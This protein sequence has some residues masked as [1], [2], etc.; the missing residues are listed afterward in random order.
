MK[1]IDDIA[2]EVDCGQVGQ[3]LQVDC[4]Q[5]GQD[6]PPPFSRYQLLIDPYLIL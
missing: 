5:A 6:L 3:D 2:N 4:G 1:D